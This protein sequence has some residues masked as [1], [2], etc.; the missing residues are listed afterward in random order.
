LSRVLGETLNKGS[1]CSVKLLSWLSKFNLLSCRRYAELASKRLE[2]EAEGGLRGRDKF[3]YCFHHVICLVCR[4][5]NRQIVMID[6]ACRCS[7]SQQQFEDS[8]GPKLS[9]EAQER[10]A[11][12]LIDS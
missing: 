8:T 6:K 3:F 12:K 10:I 11:A 7:L 9:A 1:S 2:L 5:F 4:R